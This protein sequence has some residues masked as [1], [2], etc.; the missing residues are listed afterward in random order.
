MILPDAPFHIDHASGILS[1][2]RKKKIPIRN[3]ME[4]APT[5]RFTLPV[6]WLIM[7]TTIVPAKEAPL[8]QI[9]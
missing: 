6:I 4:S 5:P 1:A 2:L 3:I 8:P 7:D 9:S